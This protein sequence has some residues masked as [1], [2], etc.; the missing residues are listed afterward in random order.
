MATAVMRSK[1]C[2]SM[3]RK[4]CGFNSVN[5]KTSDCSRRGVSVS[6]TSSNLSNSSKTSTSV[7]RKDSNVSNSSGYS[8]PGLQGRKVS[9]VS[10]SDSSV[11]SY[12]QYIKRRDSNGSSGGD[13]G[14]GGM[15]RKIS[16][17]ST[18]SNGVGGLSVVRV[19]G[20]DEVFGE[21]EQVGR[22]CGGGCGCGVWEGVSVGVGVVEGVGESVGLVKAALHCHHKTPATRTDLLRQPRPTLPSHPTI[23][24][25]AQIIYETDSNYVLVEAAAPCGTLRQALRRAGGTLGE[26]TS[27]RVVAG[28]A[29]ALGELHLRKLVHRDLTSDTI[30]ILDPQLKQVRVAG[31]ARV[32][33]AGERVV[34]AGVR[35]SWAA[36][37]VAWAV[38]GESYETGSAQD[39]WSLGVLVVVCLTGRPPWSAAHISDPHY[40]WWAAWATRATTRPP[41]RFRC[42]TPRL[43]RL[44]RRLLHPK[45]ELRAGVGE[46]EKYLGDPWVT[47]NKPSRPALD[48][49]LAATAAPLLARARA[50]FASLLAPPLTSNISSSTQA[51]RV[52]FAGECSEG[53]QKVRAVSPPA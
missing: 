50:A 25:P 17:S 24:P 42:F 33:T 6:R 29:A 44:L 28:V 22:G 36:P 52:R 15:E 53:N 3:R 14:V 38:E 26:S 32:R 48:Q 20:L 41:P 46:V 49:R 40:R 31:L 2:C 35:A 4:Q 10:R 19:G 39:A 37:E 23:L 21:L 47:V 45:A 5:R 7:R 11:S 51:R 18:C 16:A 30:Q 9:T 1:S 43:L 34:K 8:D 27:K 12:C 13:S